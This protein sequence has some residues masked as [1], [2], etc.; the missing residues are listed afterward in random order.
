M[1]CTECKKD[2]KVINQNEVIFK[3]ILNYDFMSS[4]E[5]E[6]EDYE[7]ESGD[8]IYYYFEKE[9]KELIIDSRDVCS[10]ARCICEDCILESIDKTIEIRNPHY[11]DGVYFTLNNGLNT[12]R[13]YVKF[14]HE[15]VVAKRKIRV[16]FMLKDD[17]RLTK[18]ANT[19]GVLKSNEGEKSFE[20][21]TLIFANKDRKKEIV[22]YI[23]LEEYTNGEWCCVC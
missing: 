18:I 4:I 10:G 2:F 6:F 3:G 22:K 19:A 20:S 7:L 9:H 21:G 13:D 1:I 8:I 11:G 12:A 14:C 23:C 5:R 15:E 17:M 16:K